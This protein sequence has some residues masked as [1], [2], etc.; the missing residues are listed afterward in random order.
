MSHYRHDDADRYRT[1]LIARSP[2]ERV[3]SGCGSERVGRSMGTRPVFD[4]RASA[5]VRRIGS[6]HSHQ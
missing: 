3:V 4:I 2:F 6:V 5:P 1:T